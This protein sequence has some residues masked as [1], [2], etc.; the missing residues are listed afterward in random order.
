MCVVRIHAGGDLRAPIQNHRRSTIMVLLLLITAASLEPHRCPGSV[1]ATEHC[2]V[3]S[4]QPG[5]LFLAV[6]ALEGLCHPPAVGGKDETPGPTAL[7]FTHLPR[8]VLKEERM[9]KALTLT[10]TKRR[11][12][13]ITSLLT[14]T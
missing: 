6:S 5:C 2:P 1:R 10:Y 4:H 8:E 7:G 12:H 9:K 13:R 14:G 3:P 11:A